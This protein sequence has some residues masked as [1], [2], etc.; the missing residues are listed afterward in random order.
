MHSL[1]RDGGA[2]VMFLILLPK[3]ETRSRQVFRISWSYFLWPDMG[4]QFGSHTCDPKSQPIL[5]EE[6]CLSEDWQ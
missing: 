6:Q 2:P 4:G 1:F 5:R 3:L